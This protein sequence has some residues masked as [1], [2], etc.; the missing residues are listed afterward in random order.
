MREKIL[1]MGSSVHVLGLGRSLRLNL[2]SVSQQFLFINQK[3]KSLAAQRKKPAKIAW[4]TTYRKAH[5]KVWRCPFALLA[6][7]SCACKAMRKGHTRVF[8]AR[9]VLAEM[10]RADD[11]RSLNQG[12]DQEQGQK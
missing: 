7:R 3:A 2:L 10:V 9:G 5:R 6:F 12:T 8:L 11:H 4:T 1:R